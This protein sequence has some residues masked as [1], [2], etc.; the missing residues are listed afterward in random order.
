[1]K[2]YCFL[3]LSCLL[4]IESGIKAQE[5]QKLVVKANQIKGAVEP[6]MWGVFFED[7]NLG[8]DGGIYAEL[9]KNRS[10]EFFKPMMG[11]KVLG[12]P[13]TEGD[14]LVVNRKEANAGNPRYL[15]VTLHNNVKGSI[16]LNNEGFRSMGIKKDLRYDF[17]VMY[18]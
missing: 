17:S 13:V 4:V 12:T 7:I 6:T 11:W 2:F 16:G 14:F 10:F 3:L 1:M 9:I 18:R 15:Q 8:A 5:T